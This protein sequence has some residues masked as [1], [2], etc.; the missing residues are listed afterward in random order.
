VEATVRVRVVLLVALRGSSQLAKPFL[1]AG[2]RSLPIV[3][4]V[5][6]QS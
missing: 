6:C 1:C 5:T 3:A 2:G 4:D